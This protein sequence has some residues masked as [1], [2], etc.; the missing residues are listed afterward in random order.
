MSSAW[1]SHF[2]TRPRPT[3]SARLG[4]LF[5]NQEQIKSFLISWPGTGQLFNGA[6]ICFSATTVVQPSLML[7]TTGVIQPFQPLRSS[8]ARIVLTARGGI[9]LWQRKFSRYVVICDNSRR[10]VNAGK[11]S[12]RAVEMSSSC[13]LNCHRLSATSGS[14]VLSR[15]AS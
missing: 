1:L 14:L 8:I 9:E 4:S 6:Y 3:L 15:K 7:L 5:G 12:S 2:Y 13:A 10:G 11:P